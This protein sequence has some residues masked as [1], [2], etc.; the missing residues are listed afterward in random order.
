MQVFLY[1]DNYYFLRPKIL[2]NPESQMPENSTK[3]KPPDG[4]WRPRFDTVNNVWNESADQEYK[5]IQKNK[6]KDELELKPNPILEQ[7]GTLGQ[8][9]VD[10]KLA[11][12]QA[13]KARNALGIQLTA[14]VLAR[15]K[16]EALNQSLGEQMAVLKLDV[17]NL[18]G[19][20]TDES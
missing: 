13:E 3:I 9:L 14:E 7:L 15:K 5:E 10:E 6:Y 19:G 2:D 4:L 12:K 8:Q 17:L 18:K 20:M 16:A 1:D 11:R